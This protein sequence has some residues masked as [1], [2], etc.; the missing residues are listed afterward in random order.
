MTTAENGAPTRRAVR[1]FWC[2]LFSATAASI[3]GNVEHALLNTAA[4]SPVIA[5]A[6]AVVPPAVLLGSTH[7]VAL[8]VRARTAGWAYWCALCMTAMLAGCA[9]VLSFDAL[10]ELA[11]RWAG[12]RPSVAW[13]WPMS[14]DLSIA[15]STLALLALTGAP[16]RTAAHDNA[17]VTQNGAHLHALDAPVCDGGHLT[18]ADALIGAGVT[19]IDREKVAQV[20]AELAD[21]TAPSTV[22]RRLG[23]GYQTVS[24]ISESA[25]PEA[26]S[27]WETTNGLA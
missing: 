27:A 6:A 11:V 25:A 4:G 14:I 2:T 3:A 1:F 5:A 7:G 15:V 10:R 9:F 20:L 12:Y 13:L 17:P 18:A 23:V 21:G 16:K 22:A 26:V 8:L 19:R 24:R